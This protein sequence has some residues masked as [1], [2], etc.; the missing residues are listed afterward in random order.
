MKLRRKVLA[1]VSS[2]AVLA[3]VLL[4][5]CATQPAEGNALK[6]TGILTLSVNPEIQIEYNKEGRV[7]ALSGQNED[8]KGIVA[9]YQDYIGKDCSEVLQDLIVEINEAGKLTILLQDIRTVQITLEHAAGQLPE[10]RQNSGPD[11]LV[12]VSHPVSKVFIA[13]L[14]QGCNQRICLHLLFIHLH[15]EGI[16]I[17]D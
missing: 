2:L 6:E 8:G 14:F 13:H 4:A 3:A 7:T 17:K 1:A 9:S 10:L 11:T 16:Q 5:G 12:Q 15:I